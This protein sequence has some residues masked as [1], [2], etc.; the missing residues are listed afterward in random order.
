MA[1]AAL[2]G[3]SARLRQAGGA[4]G[5]ALHLDSA[6]YIVV[7]PAAFHIELTDLLALRQAEGHVVELITPES[8]YDTYGR[9]LPDAT[10]IQAMVR[11]LSEDGALQYIT[12]CR[13]HIT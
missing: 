3:S 10:A 13:R 4:A 2:D 12:H 5:S 6:T 1:W 9:G 11:R 7:A 8:V